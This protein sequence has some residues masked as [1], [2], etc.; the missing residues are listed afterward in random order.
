[1]KHVIAI[2]IALTVMWT[3]LYWNSSYWQQSSV[4]V[5]CTMIAE[6][7]NYKTIK[8][9]RTIRLIRFNFS[10]EFSNCTIQDK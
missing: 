3:N 1:M 7:Y 5:N 8:A 4:Y 6:S 9:D 10:Y 2:A